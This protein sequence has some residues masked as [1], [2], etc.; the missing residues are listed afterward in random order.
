[1]LLEKDIGHLEYIN[2]KNEIKKTSSF[3]YFP[4]IFFSF[5][6]KIFHK[7]ILCNFQL[8][9]QSIFLRIQIICLVVSQ[10]VWLIRCT[11]VEPRPPALCLWLGVSFSCCS[12][13]V[14]FVVFYIAFSNDDPTKFNSISISITESKKKKSMKLTV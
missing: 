1:M 11:Y 12:A 3:F 7:Q 6:L 14:A 5:W 9:W 10:T 8:L 4:G 2:H 13:Q